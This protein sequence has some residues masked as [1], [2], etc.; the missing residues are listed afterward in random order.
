MKIDFK[1]F[2]YLG[3]QVT[4]WGFGIKKLFM[5]RISGNEADLR[6]DVKNV[7]LYFTPISYCTKL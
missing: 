7:P 4:C 5:D 3:Q 2:L 6:K 1:R